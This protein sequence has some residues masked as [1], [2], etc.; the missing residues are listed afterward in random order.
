MDPHGGILTRPQSLIDNSEN[1]KL[2]PPKPHLILVSPHLSG[3]GYDPSL[4]SGD[5]IFNSSGLSVGTFGCIMQTVCRG[6]QELTYV[7]DTL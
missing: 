5:I 6:R 2:L 1:G 3:N 4:S 7:P